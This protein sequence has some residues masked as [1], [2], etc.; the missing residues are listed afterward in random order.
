MTVRVALVADVSCSIC[1]NYHVPRDEVRQL[2][3]LFLCD[4]GLLS[5]GDCPTLGN[6]ARAGSASG[7]DEGGCTACT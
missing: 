6:A 4:S 3:S 5:V 2:T 1:E 7:I